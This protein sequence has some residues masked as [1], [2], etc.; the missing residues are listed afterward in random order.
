MK[1]IG[2]KGK[3]EKMREKE[4]ELLEISIHSQITVFFSITSGDKE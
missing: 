2:E 4:R 1:H 3:K